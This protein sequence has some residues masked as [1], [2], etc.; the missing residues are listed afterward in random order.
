VADALE[1]WVA[2][3][4][5]GH[6]HV[7]LD[8][9]GDDPDARHEYTWQQVDDWTRATAAAMVGTAGPG[10][11]VAILCPSG[12]EYVVA[13][14]ASLRAGVVAVPL[15][16]PDLM[17]HAGRLSAVLSDCDP[18]VI[19]TTSPRFDSVNDFLVDQGLSVPP[20]LCVDDFAGAAG[21]RL[22]ARYR[23][24]EIDPDAVA[25]LQY[26]S[27]STRLPAGVALTHRNL[28]VNTHQ[29][30]APQGITPGQGSA[31]SWL[32][33]FHDMGLILGIAAP[34]LAGGRSVVMDPLAFVMQPLR[35]LQA[36]T[37]Y[38]GTITAAPN[39]AYDLTVKRV[40]PQRR[41]G[42]DLSSMHAF[43]NG[44]EPVLPGTIRR[45][46]EAFAEVGFAPTMMAPSYG[47]AEA[48]VLVSTTPVHETPLIVSCDTSALEDG[49]LRVLSAPGDVG[50]GTSIRELVGSGRPADQRIAIVD[51]VTRREVAPGR[52]GEIWVQGGNVAQGYWERPEESTATFGGTIET[53]DGAEGGSAAGGPTATGTWL[54]TGDLGVLHEGQ[55]L[56]TGRMKDLIIVDGR[57]IYPQDLELSAQEAD[58]AISF[59]RLAAFPVPTDS[60]EGIVVVAERY[61]RSEGTA[62]L[63]S[64]VARAVRAELTRKHAVSLHDVVLVEPDSIARTSSGKIARAEVRSAYLSGGLDRVASGTDSTGDGRV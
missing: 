1:H 58:S 24:P 29:V 16:A 56:V 34:A 61:R 30:L 37:D 63:A 45:F 5:D 26:T 49:V 55:L 40:G 12:V 53:R 13:F 7:F 38:S 10:D 2:T 11:R 14:L 54:R 57:N 46:Q 64:S 18:A 19:L 41:A 27:G 62:E 52:V 23:Q 47:L 39:F 42:L 17:G 48:T 51:P 44:A 50:D 60:G 9:L 35:W 25:Y 28:A 8:Y 20:M 21:E 15:F 36:M 22:A 6:A 31:I 4:P 32:P 3:N 59:N 33:M 43:I